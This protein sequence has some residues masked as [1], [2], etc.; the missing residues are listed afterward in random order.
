MIGI[1]GLPGDAFFLQNEA[2]P[3]WFGT[4]G[5]ERMRIDANGRVVIGSTTPFAFSNFTVTDALGNGVAMY[6][7]SNNS[8]NASI[9]INALNPTANSG[10]GFMRTSALRGYIGVN[11]SNDFFLNI[12]SFNNVMDGSS[13]TG[14][15]GIGTTSPI[16]STKLD[17]TSGFKLGTNGTAMTSMIKVTQ[18]V[19]LP[20]IAATGGVL[21]QT[22]T[23]ANAA[24]GSTVYISPEQAL[25]NGV[26]IAYARV[27]AANTVEVKFYN[28]AL[29]AVDPPAMNY[30]ITV[31]Q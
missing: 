9:Y 26:V 11:P 17:V 31:I 5:N 22:F 18:N 4:S 12:G 28:A 20:S 3:L 29:T 27:S 21:V 16:A 14:G 8:G 13:I 23:V 7:E 15:M 19:D 25:A 6:G 10:F 30:Y 2:Q 24:V 1:G